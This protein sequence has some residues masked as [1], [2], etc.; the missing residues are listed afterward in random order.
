MKRELKRSVYIQIIIFGAHSVYVMCVD[1]SMELMLF[2]TGN[3]Y[4]K[5]VASLLRCNNEGI[6]KRIKWAQCFTVI[7]ST[8]AILSFTTRLFINDV[9]YISFFF[10]ARIGIL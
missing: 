2:A 5:D 9:F 8:L 7:F 6:R 3:V 10:G 4:K 1:K